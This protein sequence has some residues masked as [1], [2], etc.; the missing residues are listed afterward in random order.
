ME[1]GILMILL[2]IIILS[3]FILWSCLSSYIDYKLSKR[4]PDAMK[5]D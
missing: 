2:V 1:S 3:R 5:N 4:F